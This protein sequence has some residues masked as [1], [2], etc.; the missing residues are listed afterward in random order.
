MRP[1]ER[2]V[3]DYLRDMLAETRIAR[4]L[5]EGIGF[6][7][8]TADL[9]T[10]RAVIRTLEVIGEAAARVPPDIRARFSEVPWRDIA[11]ARNRLIHG[12]DRVDME[13]VWDMVRVDLPV[14]QPALERILSE[15]AAD[16]GAT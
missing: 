10:H 12:Y 6:D 1:E 13:L 9:R 4:E 2:D 7:E 16:E 5:V 14:L 3:Q 8:F 15:L 11:A